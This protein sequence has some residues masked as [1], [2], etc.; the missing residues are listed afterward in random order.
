MCS[1]LLAREQLSSIVSY[2]PL[3]YITLQHARRQNKAAPAADSSAQV[4]HAVS[5][6]VDGERGGDDEDSVGDERPDEVVIPR[7]LVPLVLDQIVEDR[8]VVELGDL[9][10]ERPSKEAA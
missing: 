5:A 3:L 6:H 1:D 10:R 8:H 7:K 2:T 9:Q 4:E